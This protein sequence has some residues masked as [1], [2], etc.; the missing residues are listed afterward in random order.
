MLPSTPPPGHYT[1]VAV[2]CHRPTLTLIVSVVQYTIGSAASLT[3]RTSIAVPFFPF[4]ASER[5]VVASKFMH[6]F[7]TPLRASIDL[8]YKRSIGLVELQFR[9]EIEIT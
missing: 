7:A 3:G 8:K 6:D 5:T 1:A 4:Q 9:N 2:Q